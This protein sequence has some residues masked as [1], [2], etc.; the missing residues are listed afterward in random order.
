MLIHSME[1][2]GVNGF[3]KVKM[4]DTS[5]PTL[6]KFIREVAVPFLAARDHD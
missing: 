1:L 6:L 3:Q 4:D 5:N 2:S